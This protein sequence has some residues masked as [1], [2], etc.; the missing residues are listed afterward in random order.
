MS[1]ITTLAGKQAANLNRGL[2]F[3]RL[4]Y[5]FYYIAN[6][7]M[8][9]FFKVYLEQQGLNGSQIGWLA[10]IPFLL[11]LVVNPFWGTLA[12][13]WQ[14]QRFILAGNAVMAG[15]VSLFFPAVGQFRS[16][17]LLVIVF[18]AFQIPLL[19]LLD[20][21]VIELLSNICVVRAIVAGG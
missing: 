11:A 19:A 4:Y 12:D 2:F 20:S 10:S 7:S 18:Y 15:V 13:R 3:A 14:I 17:L 6:G 9:A 16:L 8:S 21:V 1:H 5:L